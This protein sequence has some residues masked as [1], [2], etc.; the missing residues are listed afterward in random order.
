MPYVAGWGYEPPKGGE[1]VEDGWAYRSDNND[2][3]LSVEELRDLA[4]RFA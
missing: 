4:E 1:P 3:W 2:L